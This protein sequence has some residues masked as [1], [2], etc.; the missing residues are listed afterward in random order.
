M[1]ENHTFQNQVSGQ[2]CQPGENEKKDTGLNTK[3]RKILKKAL[4][5][6]NWKTIDF[7]SLKCM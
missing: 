2:E 5:I 3:T 7:A 6:I 1:S 4:P